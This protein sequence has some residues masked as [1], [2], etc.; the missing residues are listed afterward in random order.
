MT[1]VTDE[2]LAALERIPY[3]TGV[4]AA[5]VRALG[6]ASVLRVVRRGQTVFEEGAPA[7]GIVIVLTGRVKL[8][9]HSRG[10]REQV[11]HAEGP[12]ATLAEVPTFDGGGY[13]ATAVAVDDARLLF[14][15]RR[16]L[17]DLCR[18]RP[19]VALG[20]IA[21]LARRLRGFAGLIEDLAL[22]DVTT[23][24]AIWLATEAGPDGAV[25]AATRDE[26]AA[27]VGTVRE[28]VSRALTRLVRASAVERRGRALR[29]RDAALLRVIARGSYA[30]RER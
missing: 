20:V 9:R 2:R 18:R 19:A 12:G 4:P 11:L 14:V 7:G 10:G 24:V 6:D 15:P 27:R 1:K 25:P 23:R 3:L 21:V 5:D 29:V 8:V 17:M 30:K 13:V 28:L 16:T 26:I 22:R